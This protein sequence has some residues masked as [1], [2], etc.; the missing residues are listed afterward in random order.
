L[1]SMTITEDHSE[2][3]LPRSA[4]ERTSPVSLTVSGCLLIVVHV[5][6]IVVVWRSGT[7]MT[8]QDTTWNLFSIFAWAAISTIPALV[9]FEERN[10]SGSGCS[11]KASVVSQ[12]QQIILTLLSA[13]I[14]LKAW[15]NVDMTASQ[16]ALRSSTAPDMELE[17]Q[18]CNLIAGALLKDFWMPDKPELFFVIHH[19]AG[20]VGLATCLSLPAGFGFAVANGLQAECSSFFYNGLWTFPCVFGKGA[21]KPAVLLYMTTFLVSH[22][23]GIAIGTQFVFVIPSHGPL[24]WTWWRV[25]YCSVCGLLVTMRLGGQVVLA[26]RICSPGFCPK[27]EDHEKKP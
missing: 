1:I 26:P 19:F 10:I 9:R 4:L 8:M 16:W 21:V 2:G 15:A 20:I 25:M 6:A 3:P 23:C 24:W 13:V 27:L 12:I 11:F 22:I 7:D 17:R 14:V 18:A 5:V